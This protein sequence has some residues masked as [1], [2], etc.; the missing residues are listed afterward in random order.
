MKA[1]DF[2]KSGLGHMEDRATTYD[3]PQG[4]RSMGKCVRMF[5]ELTGIEMDET[6]GWLFM[7]CLKMVRSQ[8]GKFRADN[9]E[10]LAAYAGL[11]G[12]AAHREANTPG[13]IY[14]YRSAV[15]PV[16]WPTEA[17]EARQE[18]VNQNGNTGE[19]YGAVK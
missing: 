18:I 3:A 5:E 9:F 8:Q 17:Q 11:A 1:A 12:E 7:C 16:E 4:E 14:M 13:Q 15:E 2:L 19:H 6:Q 10:D